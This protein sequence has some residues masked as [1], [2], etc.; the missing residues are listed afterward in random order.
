MPRAS[1]CCEGGVLSPRSQTRAL[2][3]RLLTQTAHS[4]V[5][6]STSEPGEPRDPPYSLTWW[7]AEENAAAVS[8]PETPETSVVCPLW[9]SYTLGTKLTSA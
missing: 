6:V 1:R 2:Q 3:H 9:K 5:G 8:F 4:T 7:T